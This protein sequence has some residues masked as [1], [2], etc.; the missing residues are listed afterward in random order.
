MW[1]SLS[2]KKFE[3]GVLQI[4]DHIDCKSGNSSQA[5]SGQDQSI[6]ATYVRAAAMLLIRAACQT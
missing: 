4:C 5:V 1:V 2:A 3:G 6:A